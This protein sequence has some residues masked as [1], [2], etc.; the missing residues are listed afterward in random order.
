MSL[1]DYFAFR[2]SLTCKKGFS[3]IFLSV[4]DNSFNETGQLSINK[5]SKLRFQIV[6]APA[7]ILHITF[8][9]ELRY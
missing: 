5:T 6:D 8:K 4:A 9:E 3:E 2:I 7:Y 1:Q